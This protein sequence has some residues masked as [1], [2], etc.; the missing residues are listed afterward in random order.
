MCGEYLRL[1]FPVELVGTLMLPH[2][3]TGAILLKISQTFLGCIV[4][5]VDLAPLED[6]D[7]PVGKELAVI[8]LL[9]IFH[10]L[11]EIHLVRFGLPT[12]GI[13]HLVH[14]LAI[15]ASHRAEAL[16]LSNVFSVACPIVLR[17]ACSH[18]HD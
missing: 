13:K 11:S 8:L 7:H 12:A 14:L 16:A 2:T 9:S 1:H 3:V 15:L 6:L 17:V 4:K 18:R 5:A 10:S